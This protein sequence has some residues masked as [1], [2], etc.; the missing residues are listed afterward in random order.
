MAR[1]VY[2]C[3]A[4]DRR[5][6]VEKPMAASAD[7]ALCPSCQAPGRRVFTAPGIAIKGAPVKFSG[8]EE[9]E[10]GASHPPGCEGCGQGACPWN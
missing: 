9:S 4:C 1:Y 5:F 8:G 2:A 7:P 6:E 3:T 10:N